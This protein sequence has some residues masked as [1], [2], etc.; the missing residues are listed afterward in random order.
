MDKK[1]RIIIPGIYDDVAPLTDEEKRLYE[2]I[3]FDLDEYCK[4]VGVEQLLHDTKAR[5]NFRKCF[6]NSF[7]YTCDI[8]ND[9]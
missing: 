2:Q 5:N 3:D 1:G 4:D 9:V 6:C 7:I 8:V